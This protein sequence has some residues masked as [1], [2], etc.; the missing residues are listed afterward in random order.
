MSTNK[1]DVLEVFQLFYE[2]L[3]PSRPVTRIKRRRLESE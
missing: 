2:E 1:L 3:S